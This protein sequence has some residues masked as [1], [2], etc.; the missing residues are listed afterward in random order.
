M[1]KRL[2]GTALSTCL[3][4][5][6]LLTLGSCRTNVE[7]SKSGQSIS[8]VAQFDEH[9]SKSTATAF[10]QG[11]RLGVYVTKKPM[12]LLPAGNYADNVLF[13]VSP[14]G[15]INAAPALYYPEGLLGAD[16]FAYYP[17]QSG[18]AN[19]LEV[20]FGIYTDQTDFSSY[21]ASDLCYGSSRS[22]TAQ[23]SPL[24]VQFSHRLA[25]VS[26]QLALQSVI[27]GLDVVGV[28]GVTLR[29][30]SGQTTLNL[31]DGSLA[32]SQSTSALVRVLMNRSDNGSNPSAASFQAVLPAQEIPAGNLL[33]VAVELASGGGATVV[34]QYSFHL[35]SGLTLAGGAS[36]I[37]AL[38]LSDKGLLT[39]NGLPAVGA[40]DSESH[41]GGLTELVDNDFT[42]LW[43]LPAVDYAQ[44]R[45]AYLVI[46]DSG[47]SIVPAPTREFA[48]SEFSIPD[49]H[50]AELCRYKFSFSADAQSG[51]SYPY[52]IAAI[53]FVDHRGATVELCKSLIAGRVTRSGAYTLG[54]EN[55]YILHIVDS[56]V[57]DW[58]D[59]SGSGSIGGGVANEFGLELIEPLFDYSVL[60]KVRLQIDG[61]DYLF[62]GIGY[63]AG[64]NK[65]L[66]RSTEFSFPDIN[67]STPAVYP[68]N[69]EQVGLRTSSDVEPQR[70][71]SNIAVGRGGRITLQVF[72]GVVVGVLSSSSVIGYGDATGS[73]EIEYVGKVGSNLFSVVYCNGEA[74]ASSSC[75]DVKTMELTVNGKK[76][77][78]QGY[79]MNG[80]QFAARSTAGVELVGL[81]DSPATYPYYITKVELRNA[82]DKKLG[83]ATFD[84]PLRVTGSGW[85]TI[86]LM[87]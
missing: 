30:L 6:T 63:L 46:E 8:L 71:G 49:G 4:L 40:W 84:T 70:F 20:F 11:D 54:I 39:L 77:T 51:I 5:L 10:E 16:I 3:I 18:F 45:G 81:P 29:Q 23:S 53:R 56:D 15:G 58:G 47:S 1:S 12:D 14:R 21:S 62:S 80:N 2:V 7:T 17:Y 19:A 78:L 74:A 44:V 25:R 69:I 31:S 24:L 61:Y 43:R 42:V 75:L 9:I 50:S 32:V 73:G 59:V 68:F 28:S 87:E 79:S 83:E 41:G 22:V 64:S 72:R 86:D 60:S 37:F 38:E 33:T 35:T 26:V 65:L 13:E 82:A 76:V 52:R 36:N 67:G 66:A 27:D 34:R 55:G 85:V 48:V 57:N